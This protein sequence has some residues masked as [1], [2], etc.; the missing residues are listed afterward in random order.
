[1]KEKSDGNFNLSRY[2]IARIIG[3]RALQL[4]Y[5]APPLVEVLEGDD[6]IKIAKREFLLGVIPLTVYRKD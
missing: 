5:G 6:S 1:M 2:E 3:A 4:S